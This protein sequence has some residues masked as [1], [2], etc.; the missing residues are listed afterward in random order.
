MN[1]GKIMQQ[2]KDMQEKMKLMQSDL[3]TIEVIG[4]SGGGM[5]TVHMTGDHRVRLV[6]IEDAIWQDQDK[7]MIEDLVAA[8]V[9]AA[10]QQ[11]TETVKAKQNKIMAGLPLPPGFV[12]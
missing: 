5:V 11:V 3:A 9:N 2:A 4:E 8:A 12:L 7:A 1:I 10:T 6:S